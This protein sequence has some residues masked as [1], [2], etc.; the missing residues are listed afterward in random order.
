MSLSHV[1]VFVEMIQ[2]LKK[3]NS[4]LEMTDQINVNTKY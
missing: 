2:I 1:C 3:L 4:D